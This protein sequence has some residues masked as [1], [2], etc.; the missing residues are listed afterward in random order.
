MTGDQRSD[1]KLPGA[2]E[3]KI[4]LGDLL[5]QQAIGA[6]DHRQTVDP[7]KRIIDDDQ[8]VANTVETAD[9]APDEPG[10]RVGD[11]A[12]LLE[13][14]AIAQSLCAVKLASRGREANLQRPSGR[15]HPGLA[16][17][18]TLEHRPWVGAE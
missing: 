10:G 6:H 9:V 1:L 14:N 17:V 18:G 12:T 16:R 8:M 7:R 15:Q 3:A 13:E 4:H 11:G 5:P 2:V